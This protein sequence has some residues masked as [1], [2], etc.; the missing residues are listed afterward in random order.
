[1]ANE[2][3]LRFKAMDDRF[4]ALD[5]EIQGRFNGMTALLGAQEDEWLRRVYSIGRT[6]G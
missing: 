6:G 4:I 2:M 5:R 1:M 3:E